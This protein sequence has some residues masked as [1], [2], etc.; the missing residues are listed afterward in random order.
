MIQSKFYPLTVTEKRNFNKYIVIS[1]IAN[2]VDKLYPFPPDLM[3]KTTH[4]VLPQINKFFKENME[5][6]HLPFHY[7]ISQIKDDWY[8]FN[9][10]NFNYKSHVIA[11]ACKN[12]YIEEKFKNA[13][14]IVLQDNFDQ[15]TLDLRS[16]E[17]ITS[18]IISPLCESFK[19]RPNEG[20]FFFDEI[21]NYDL[22]NRDKELYGLNLDYNYNVVKSTYLDPFVF[23][24]HMQKYL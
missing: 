23:R 14:I 15:N 20:V 9:V 3:N 12:Y 5:L 7:Y 8:S 13:I 17:V 16:V 2:F 6:R 4:F 19:I 1:H 21:F 18:T 24:L 11:K 22:Y 10:E